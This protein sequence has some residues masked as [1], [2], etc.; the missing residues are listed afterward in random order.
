[1]IQSKSYTGVINNISPCGV[2]VESKNSFP[3]GEILTMAI[4][5]KREKDAKFTGQ[6]V[7]TNNKGLGVK[8]A[9]KIN[10]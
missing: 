1:M 9:K 8:F 10:K 5:L 6:I 4:P 7:W 2:F 3:V